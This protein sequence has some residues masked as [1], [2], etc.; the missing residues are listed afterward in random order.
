MVNGYRN[1][2]LFGYLWALSV[3]RVCLER[4]VGLSARP[5]GGHWDYKSSHREVGSDRTSRWTSSK[6]ARGADPGQRRKPMPL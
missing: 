5:S 1:A 2:V 6:S 4:C 3:L